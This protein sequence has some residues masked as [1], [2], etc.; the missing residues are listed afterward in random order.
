MVSSELEELR[1]VC[2]RIAIVTDGRISGILPADRKS[3]DFGLL[4]VSHRGLRAA[5]GAQ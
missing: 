5:G 3:A 2:D 4:M 1:A